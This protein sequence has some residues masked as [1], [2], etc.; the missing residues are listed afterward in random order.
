MT[1]EAIENNPKST[2]SEAVESGTDQEVVK[3]EEIADTSAETNDAEPQ[4]E[5]DDDDDDDGEED[6]DKDTAPSKDPELLLI[7][8]SNYKEEGNNYFKEKDYEKA[9]RSYRRGTN[10]LK[11]LNVGN[12]GDEQVKTLL[13]SLQTNL[14]MMFFKLNKHKQS[15]QVATSALKIDGANVKARYRRA[16]ARR[17]LG[18]HEGARDDLREALKEDPVNSAVKKELASLKR[19]LDAL[20]KAQKKSMQKAFSKGALLYDDKEEQRERKE[21]EEAEKKKQEEELLKKRKVEWEDECVKRMAKGEGAISFEDYEKMIKEAEEKKKKEEE[22]KRKEEEKRRKEARRKAREVAKAQESDS[23]DDE[24]TEKDLAQLRGYK[25]TSDGRVTSYFTR[26]QST[27]EKT[28]IGD[29][30]PKRLDESPTAGPMLID[31]TKSSDSKGNPSAWNQ[32]GTWEE[33]DTSEWCRNHLIKRLKETR[34]DLG[35]L[36]GLVTDVKDLSGDASVANVGGKKR[37]I[38][39]FHGKVMIDIREADTEEVIASGSFKIP[40]LCS[41]HHEELEVEIQG[42]KKAPSSDR[43]MTAIECRDGLVSQVRES[44]KIWVSDFNKEY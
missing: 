25:K 6:S 28:L 21:K 14:S 8:A 33:K 19:E 38:F 2:A 13:I 20:K 18:E 41:T 34:V 3:N 29:I 43:A 39:D 37:Y 44:V 1:S 15:A 11:T 36:L 17:K 9:S 16:L 22:K 5:S 12:T 40:D 4:T 24:L 27:E 26:E 32:A 31:P 42:W 7:K 35:S 23:D 30:T 10:A